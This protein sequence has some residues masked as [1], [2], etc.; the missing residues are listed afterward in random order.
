MTQVTTDIRTDL[1]GHIT[2]HLPTSRSEGDDASGAGE[3]QDGGEGRWARAY[4]R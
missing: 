1:D 4:L 2:H 3:A